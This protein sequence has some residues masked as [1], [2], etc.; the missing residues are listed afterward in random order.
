[1]CGVIND[2]RFVDASSLCEYI[3]S[4]SS[5]EESSEEESSDEEE[6]TKKE[7][8]TRPNVMR[9]IAVCNS[10]DTSEINIISVV[11]TLLILH[12]HY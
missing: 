8:V 7:K 3:K 12:M 11:V 10:Y 6:K 9:L 5:E 2:E 1:V 4:S